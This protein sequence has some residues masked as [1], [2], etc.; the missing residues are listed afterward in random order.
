MATPK[1]ATPAT[2][3][4][5]TCSTC[6]KVITNPKSIANGQGNLCARHA[7]R[8]YT[9]A[10]FAQHRQS[11][12]STVPANFIKV[13]ALHKKIVATQANPKTAIAGLSVNKMVTAIGRDRCL[14]GSPHPIATPIYAPNGHRWVNPWLATKNGLLAIAT[15][16]FTNAPKK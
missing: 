4:P 15:G 14:S 11:M 5:V 13:A 12:Q 10:K 16:N 2:P 1:K 6:G 9:P 3:A 8:G 7:K